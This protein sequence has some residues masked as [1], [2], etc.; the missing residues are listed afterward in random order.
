MNRDEILNKFTASAIIRGQVIDTNLVEFGGRGA[1]AYQF[2][3]PDPS[4]FVSQLPLGHPGKMADLYELT[5]EDIL[6]YLEELGKRLDYKTNPHLQ[7]ALRESYKTAP[8]TPPIMDY[9]YRNMPAIFTRAAVIELVEANIGKDYLE[10]WVPTKLDD[11]RTMNIRA[12]GARTLHI[13]AGNSP[14]VSAMTIL[15]NAITRSD[16][17]IKTPSN[18]PFTALA[19]AQTMIDMAPDHPLT[20]HIS[21]AYWKGG[22][23]AVESMLYQPQH[24][25]KIVAWG[26]FA[27]VKHVTRYIQPGLELITYDPKVSASIIG[28]ETFASETSMRE[29][30][31][32]L[33][34]DF[35]AWNQIGCVNA[36]LAYVQSGT[37]DE[38]LQRINKLGEY[39][40]EALLKLPGQI[41]TQPKEVDRELKEYVESVR[42]QDDWYNVI[43]GEQ[44]EG[45]VIVSQLPEPVSFAP[46]LANR[47]V[48]MVP[49]DTLDEVMKVVTAYTQTVGIYPESLKRQ[50]RDKLPLYGAQRL[51]PLGYACM[52]TINGPHDGMEPLR[53]CCKWIV[54]E[55]CTPERIKPLWAD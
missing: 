15:R 48:N 17:I 7:T 10:G 34:T 30:A 28:A 43:G 51:V 18:D 13:A 9:F 8:S 20:K 52:S 35:G 25:E 41:S 44:D 40:Y 42:L 39:A 5:F 6:D 53:R 36:R 38:G 4:T 2:L 11:G 24:I 26:G 14:H 37:D 47:T 22:D 49:V 3:S 54:E 19:I 32:R 55:E 29:A 1:N 27:S 46:Y 21:V 33:A 45:A 31:Q 50:L 23:E 16:S 12:F